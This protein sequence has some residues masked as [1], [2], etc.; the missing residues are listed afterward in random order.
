MSDCELHE[1]C[2]SFYEKLAALPSTVRLMRGAYC[3]W[4][5]AECARY[6]VYKVLGKD[7]I[8][9]DLYPSDAKRVSELT[10]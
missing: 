10:I 9:A 3:K 4:N 8:P 1:T 7:K 5:Y 2:T 6:Q